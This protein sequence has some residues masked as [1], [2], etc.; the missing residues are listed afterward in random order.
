MMSGVRSLE[1]ARRATVRICDEAGTH[2][3]QGLMLPLDG[4]GIVIL[5]CHHVVAPLTERDLYVAIPQPSGQLG[6]PV[7]ATYDP[8]RSRPATDA[9]VLRIAEPS[10]LE[11]PLLHAINLRTYRGWLPDPAIC[12]GHWQTDSFDARVASTTKLDIPVETPGPW[13]D[14]PSRYRLPLAFRL[15]DPTDARPGISGSVACYQNGVLGLVHF[16][17]SAGPDQQREAYLVP[18][19]VWTEGW[20]TLTNLIEPLVDQQVAA[21]LSEFL[22]ALRNFSRSAYKV[23]ELKFPKGITLEEVYV[24][25][26]ATHA[27]QHAEMNSGTFFLSD[28][29]RSAF[30]DGSRQ[31]L[32]EGPAGSGKST[33]LRQIARHAWD[34]PDSVGLDRRYLALPIRLRS[35][36]QS[37]GVERE[38]RIRRAMDQALDIEITGSRLP[39]GFYDTWPKQLDV[40]WLFLLDGLDEVPESSREDVGTWLQ[41]LADEGVPLLVTTRPIASLPREFQER[42]IQERFKRYSVQ[43]FS[44][45]QQKQLSEKW[46]GVRAG[47][48][49]AAFAHFAGGELGGTPLLLTIAAIIYYRLPGKLPT[50][51][52]S[53]Y[54]EFFKDTWEELLKHIDRDEIRDEIG[55]ELLDLRWLVPMCLKHI[56]LNMTERNKQESA[57]DF[58]DDIESLENS[59]ATLLKGKLKV[60]SEAAISRA[61]ALFEFL[62]V[63]SG[64]FWT[65]AHEFE[66]L[67]P[68]FREFLAAEAIYDK[69]KNRRLHERGLNEVLRR[70]SDVSWRQVV[71]FLI[72]ILSEDRLVIRELRFLKDLDHPFGLAFVG[73]AISE[74]ANVDM[75]FTEEAI[76]NLCDVIRANAKGWFLERALT[77]KFTEASQLLSALLPFMG[78]PELSQHANKLKQDLV[79]FAY[80]FGRRSPSAVHDLA[81]LRAFDALNQIASDP[82]APFLVRATAAQQLYSSGRF[83]ESHRTFNELVN[84]APFYPN[85]WGDLVDILAKLGDVEFFGALADQ[86]VLAGPYFGDLVDRLREV[87]PDAIQ[88]LARIIVNKD[89]AG[90]VR[91]PS[92]QEVS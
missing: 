11:R 90:R 54:R 51:R 42:V 69:L 15:A 44:S 3:G 81:M 40:P 65:S 45:E 59:I 6:R 57:L 71:L 24:P 70:F 46:L 33:L 21:G 12:L 60:A 18:L 36:A 78:V 73:V 68:T 8:Q 7:R 61:K 88:A 85:D 43:P 31:I 34:N 63:R 30:G 50:S 28:A 16:S 1:A 32:I 38:V 77:E 10:P 37:D 64:I 17:R 14:P 23:L 25:L 66:W 58:E 82:E 48:F 72:A 13:P 55:L 35:F 79:Q 2:K 91:A 67:H 52:S 84:E 26:E 76:Q 83:E 20:S 19:S 56:A 75:P 87:N 27:P 47:D 4:E 49:Q 53:L 80:D 92:V 39:P 86:G 5:T 22:S 74:G 41:T 29:I 9:V 62:R 89:L